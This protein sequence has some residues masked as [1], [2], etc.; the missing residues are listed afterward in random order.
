MIPDYQSLM[1]PVLSHLGDGV[2][3]RS[4][5]VKDAMADLFNL[6][7]EERAEMLPSGRQRTID[8]RVGW[9][10]TYL[11]QSGLVERPSRGQ[12]RITEDGR[13]VLVQHPD[14]IDLKV[15]E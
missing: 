3:R 2:V 10:L 11:A 13:V 15:L 12:V 5:E 8:N 6:S 1:C 4:R 7:L 9:A 14:R